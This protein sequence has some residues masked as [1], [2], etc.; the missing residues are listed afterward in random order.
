MDPV[1]GHTENIWNEYKLATQ[2]IELS[3]RIT[4]GTPKFKN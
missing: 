1:Y 2:F 4:R 3:S